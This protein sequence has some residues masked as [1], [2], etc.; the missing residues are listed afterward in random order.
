MIIDSPGIAAL[1]PL[2]NI[3]SDLAF[4]RS[5]LREFTRKLKIGR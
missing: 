1:V 3:L 2:T 4:S 5:S